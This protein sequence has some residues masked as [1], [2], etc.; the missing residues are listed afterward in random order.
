MPIA[1]MAEH[2]RLGNLELVTAES[3]TCF[4]FLFQ[5]SS[6]QFLVLSSQCELFKKGTELAHGKIYLPP[7]RA[8]DAWYGRDGRLCPA[9]YSHASR[10]VR[11]QHGAGGES[12]GTRRIH[13]EVLFA[14]SIQDSSGALRYHYSCR[15]WLRCN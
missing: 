13:S 6:S 10:R 7:R 4:W 14:A 15:R 5:E 12:R 11:A 3:R 9:S 2:V 1:D 8:K